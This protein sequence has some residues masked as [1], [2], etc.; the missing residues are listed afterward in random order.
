M[1]P[2]TETLTTVTPSRTEFRSQLLM[3]KVSRAE[4]S[5]DCLRDVIASGTK[6]ETGITSIS[7]LPTLVDRLGIP[8]GFVIAPQY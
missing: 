1:N 2:S 5:D 7:Q 8:C 3:G 4:I 6:P